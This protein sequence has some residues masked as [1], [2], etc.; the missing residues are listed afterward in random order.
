MPSATAPTLS[1]NFSPGAL[2]SEEQAVLPE[3]KT[4]AIYV[5]WPFCEKKCP[6]CDFNS[7]VR[8]HVDQERWR[9][10]LLQELSYMAS[11]TQG[12][13]VGSVFFGGG[14]PSLMPPETVAAVIAGIS[15]LWSVDD[16]L[17]ITLEANPSSVEAARFAGYRE[18]GVN[19]VSLGIQALD[20]EALSFLG[21]LHNA[22]EALAALEVARKTFDRYSFDLIYARP[23]QTLQGWRDELA[24]ALELHGGHVSLYQLTIEQDTAFYRRHKRGEFALPDE[25]LAA[26]LFALTD[27]MTKDAGLFAYE[28]SNH[29]RKGEECRHNLTYWQAGYYVGVGPGAHGR[30][31]VVNAG[32]E[33]FRGEAL[34]TAQEKRPELWLEQVNS[35][36]HGTNAEERISAETRAHEAVM[37]GLRLTD[38]IDKTLFADRIGTPLASVIDGDALADL[39][40]LGFLEDS[41]RRLRTTDEGRLLLNS[42]TGRLLG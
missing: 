27:E 9:E 39:V 38:G 35:C 30:L 17:E 33:V 6:Y 2:T 23:E 32:G 41:P 24:R 42:L 20:D 14:T 22:S 36:G 25:D 19:R 31:P 16:D 5:H 11:R 3:A 1:T 40:A 15:R 18:A 8:A 12:Y 7:H 4:L 29:A 26:D 21:R 28:I 10:A 37:M 13:R 34:A